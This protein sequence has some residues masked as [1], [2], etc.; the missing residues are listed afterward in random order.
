MLTTPKVV[1]PRADAVGLVHSDAG[2]LLPPGQGLQHLP[3]IGHDNHVKKMMMME[4]M[5]KMVVSMPGTPAPTYCC[6]Q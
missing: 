2:E 4:L 5:K 1:A 3:D 6:S